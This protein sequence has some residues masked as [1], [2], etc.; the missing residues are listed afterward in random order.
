MVPD[1]AAVVFDLLALEPGGQS[2]TGPHL[3]NGCP[4]VE[5]VAVPPLTNGGEQRKPETPKP[6]GRRLASARRPTPAKLGGAGLEL[7]LADPRD[8][9]RLPGDLRPTLP[10]QGLVNWQ[11]A[12][13]I[14]RALESLAADRAASGQGERL[15]V[16]V[17][18]LYAAQAE[19]LR[20]LIQRSPSLMASS[21][22][23]S[24]GEPSSFREREF[25]VVLV[26]MTRSH[27]NR[28]VPYGEGPSMLTLALTRARAKLI[29]FGDA[30]T[31][32]RRSHWDGPV[33]HL[34]TAAAALER[35]FAGR[36]VRY[37]QG[38]GAHPRAFHVRE[39]KSP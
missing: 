5:F 2:P 24:V 38:Q 15:A 12:Q 21:L 13:A 11:E 32:T 37:L 4:A 16:G 20:S 22:A 25:A 28:A 30:G 19:L 18:A 34:D 29:L 9:E 3:A 7:D 36:L 6:N 26:G 27:S 33:D 10:G 39:G 35:Q 23:I 1:L 17:I 31:L 14:V 8:R